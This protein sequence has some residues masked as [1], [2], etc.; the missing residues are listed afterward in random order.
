MTGKLPTRQR[1]F[2]LAAPPLAVSA[3]VASLAMIGGAMMINSRCAPPP[4]DDDAGM[5]RSTF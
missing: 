2:D 1:R 5:R 3:S 4:L